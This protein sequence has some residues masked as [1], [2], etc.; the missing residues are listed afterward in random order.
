MDRNAPTE[1]CD[2]SR[3]WA[4]VNSPAP[5]T[6][7]SITYLGM[8]VLRMLGHASMRVEPLQECRAAVEAE[9]APRVRGTCL[10]K[11]RGNH[12]SSI[13]AKTAERAVPR[14]PQRFADHNSRERRAD[15]GADCVLGG[16]RAGD[17]PGRG[18]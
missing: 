18:T 13:F 17:P 3:N 12:G 5:G 9:S 10:C 14:G 11:K 4:S 15:R 7:R 2:I 16:Y 1:V 6:S 8:S